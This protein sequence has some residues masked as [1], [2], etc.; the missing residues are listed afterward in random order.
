MGFTL[1]KAAA[2]LAVA[3]GVAMLGGLLLGTVA[4]R[5]REAQVS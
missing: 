3:A 1:A 2:G 5:G 4:M